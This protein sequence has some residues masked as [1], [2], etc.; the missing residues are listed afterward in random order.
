[1]PHCARVRDLGSEVHANF[2]WLFWLVKL[3]CSTW[4][5]LCCRW[6]SACR[7]GKLCTWLPCSW[8][9]YFPTF[10]YMVCA[11]FLILTMSPNF[12]FHASVYCVLQTP[13]AKWN[14]YAY[15][16]A[17]ISNFLYH[18]GNIFLSTSIL[19]ASKWHMSFLKFQR[20]VTYVW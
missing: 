10:L 8:Y 5:L 11:M 20:C 16:G 4:K 1:M 9:P 18:K 13:S 15:G 6:N 12:F 14:I 17:G 19:E 7:L 3:V 2:H